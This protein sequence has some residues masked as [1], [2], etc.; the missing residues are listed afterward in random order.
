MSLGTS[1]QWTVHS[2]FAQKPDKGDKVLIYFQVF[3][4]FRIIY[5]PCTSTCWLVDNRLSTRTSCTNSR[6][7]SNGEATTCN[8][9]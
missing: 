5:M 3:S 9:H 2:S 4:C 8:R 6:D 7:E 1:L